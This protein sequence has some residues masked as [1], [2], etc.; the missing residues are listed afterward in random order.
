MQHHAGTFTYLNV[1]DLREKSGVMIRICPNL[2]ADVLR[3]QLGD[4]PKRMFGPRF[5]IPSRLD[6]RTEIK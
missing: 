3:R 5:E 1:V 4:Y 6:L 2:N